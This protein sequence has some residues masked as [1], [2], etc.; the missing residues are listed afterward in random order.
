MI[1]KDQISLIEKYT[2]YKKLYEFLI[3]ESNLI[4]KCDLC[5]CSI[6]KVSY[7][8]KII[9]EITNFNNN[10]IS[11]FNNQ[12]LTN[13]DKLNLEELFIVKKINYY[14]VNYDK[15]NKIFCNLCLYH[16]NKKLKIL[17]KSNNDYLLI[18]YISYDF[19]NYILM[20][21]MYFIND[22]SINYK[23]INI[24]RIIFHEKNNLEMKY[25]II[26]NLYELKIEKLKKKNYEIL[27]N[28]IENDF[29]FN[30]NYLKEYLK[31][32]YD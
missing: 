9:Y 23:N 24:K 16:V 19:Y 25:I 28:L 29:N 15:C 20:N 26:N 30:L 10:I 7:K 22:Q 3:G 8:N 27:N 6:E 32:K 14:N 11:K 5:N 1:I 4:Y 13:F 31:L 12:I 18:D 21:N 2:K 17:K